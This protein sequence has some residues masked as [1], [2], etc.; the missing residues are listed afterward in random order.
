VFA[1]GPGAVREMGEDYGDF[2]PVAGTEKIF[3]GFGFKAV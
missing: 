2:G 3:R 1:I